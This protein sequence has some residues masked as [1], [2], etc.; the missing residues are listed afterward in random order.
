MKELLYYRAHP[1]KLSPELSRR[2]KALC[3]AAEKK[4]GKDRAAESFV[5]KLKALVVFPARQWRYSAVGLATACAAILVS[6]F[7]VRH[8]YPCRIGSS[9]RRELFR[10]GA[11]A[12]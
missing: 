11:G 6:L 1:A 7:M 4:S 5:E 2:L 12:R 10:R 8:E 9:R 3:Q